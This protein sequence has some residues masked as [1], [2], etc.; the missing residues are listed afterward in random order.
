LRQEQSGFIALLVEQQKKQ[1]YAADI[2]INHSD[3][4][5]KCGTKTKLKIGKTIKLGGV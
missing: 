5:C 4:Q 1:Q 3:I 2:D